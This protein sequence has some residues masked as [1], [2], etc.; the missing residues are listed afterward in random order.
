MKRVEKITKSI[1]GYNPYPETMR[2][3][4]IER[5]G[6]AGQ[7]GNFEITGEYTDELIRTIGDF[8][9]KHHGKLNQYQMWFSK[10]IQSWRL[11]FGRGITQ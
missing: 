7:N 6:C 1:T 8:I 10:P 11:V 5:F 4:L 2:K 3:E 9:S